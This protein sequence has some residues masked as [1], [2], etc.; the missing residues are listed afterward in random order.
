MVGTTPVPGS[1]FKIKAFKVELSVIEKHFQAKHKEYSPTTSR[2]PD[3]HTRQRCCCFSARFPQDGHKYILEVRPRPLSDVCGHL[4]W[5]APRLFGSLRPA[6]GELSVTVKCVD[7]PVASTSESAVPV[8]ACSV[9]SKPGSASDAPGVSAIISSLVTSV[10]RA[11]VIWS[12][13][14]TDS[15]SE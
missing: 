13:K 9:C 6:A 8:L 15:S 10:A 4:L 3:T 2:T 1:Y 11:L 14:M 12:S 5:A 7:I